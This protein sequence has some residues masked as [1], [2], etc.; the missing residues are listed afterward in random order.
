M[1]VAGKQGEV[2]PQ[3]AQGSQGAKGDQGSQGPK[4]DQGP[5]GIPGTANIRLVQDNGSS[6]SCRE[7]EVLASVICGDGAA[8]S[9]SQMHSAKCAAPNG[10]VGICMKP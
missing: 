10:V 8:A 9:V 5:P 2:G 7:G 4:G 1:G 3:G 6:L